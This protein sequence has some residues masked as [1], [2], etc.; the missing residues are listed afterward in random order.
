MLD[1]R[2]GDG[3]ASSPGRRGAGHLARVPVMIDSSRG[4][5]SRPACAACRARP[6]VNSISLK[7]ARSRSSNRP[8]AAALRRGRHRHGLRRGRV[9]PTRWS[10]RSRSAPRL[11]VLTERSAS[12]RTSSSIRTSS[13]SPPASRSTTPTPSTSSRPRADQAELPGAKVSGGVSNVSF[14]F[15]GNN[16]VREAIHS[17]F[18]Y[19]AI[20]RHGHGHRQRGQLAVY[21]DCPGSCASGGGRHPQ[22]PRRRD[23][24]AAGLADRTRAT[25][26]AA[27][28]RKT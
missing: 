16:P 23:R 5:S 14:S 7:E 17:V 4:R 21:D 8:A 19:H 25:A 2:R 1:G 24:A 3:H 15:R 12:P 6:I 13:P 22:P 11:P 20:G 26:A 28:R 27:A 10:A 9:R 18:L